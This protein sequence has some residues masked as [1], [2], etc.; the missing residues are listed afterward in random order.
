MSYVIVSKEFSSV[1]AAT[2]EGVD[3]IFLGFFCIV[4]VNKAPYHWLPELTDD[5]PASPVIKNLLAV[6]P[7]KQLLICVSFGQ[8]QRT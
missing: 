3:N 7:F 5:R 2:Q 1:E 4:Y 8:N 6:F